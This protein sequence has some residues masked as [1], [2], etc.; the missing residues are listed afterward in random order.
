[1]IDAAYSRDDRGERHFR[2]E[3][4]PLDIGGD[5]AAIR[6]DGV[7]GITVARIGIHEGRAFV[8]PGDS[9]L[10][11]NGKAVSGSRWLS[12]GDTLTF[13]AGR[14]VVH[15]RGERLELHAR[16]NSAPELP[17]AKGD[18]ES[19][20]TVQP[21][22][23]HP[24]RGAGV[25]ARSGSRPVVAALVAVFA[26]LAAAAWFLFTANSVNVI[27]EPQPAEMA[28]EGT[29]FKPRV[30]GRYL[31]RPGEYRVVAELEGYRPL[32]ET[33]EVGLS[34]NQ[35]FALQME[36]LPGLLSVSSGE[37]SGAEV[38]IDGELIGTTP[39][40]DAEVSAGL[41]RLLVRARN[42]LQ[43]EQEIEI[44]GLLESQ[45][46]NITLQPNWAPVDLASEPAGATVAVDGVAVGTT[47]IT[48]EIEAGDREVSLSLAG[49]DTES[50]LI[51]VVAGEAQVLE[52]FVLPV[53]DGRL[54]VATTPG[55]VNVSVNGKFR[56]RTPL[57]LELEPNQEHRLA[58]AKPGY[59][60]ASRRVTVAPE[61]TQSLNVRL[62]PI[63]GSVRVVASPADAEL[64]VDGVRRG[65][66][67]QVLEL[68]AAPHRI[69]LRKNGY[70]THTETVTPRRGLE[71]SLTVVLKTV[72][73]AAAAEL[74]AKIDTPAGKLRLIQGGSLRMGSVRRE[75]G[76]RS[77]EVRRDV[78]LT[79]E[80]YI[81][82][83]EVTN[84]A[85]REFMGEHSSGFVGGISLDGDDQPVV[86]VSWQLAARFC[87]WMSDRDGLPKAYIDRDGRLVAVRPMNTGY[88]LPSEA[89][90]AWVAR[91]AGG[92][93]P[94]RY[95]WGDSLP[96]PAGAG[97]FA[98]NASAS[99]VAQHLDNYDDGFPV[100]APVGSF[101]ANRLGLKDLGGNVSEW[102]HDYYELNPIDPFL[103][104]VDP[105]GPEFGD[106]H[107][108]RG[109]SWMKGNISELRSAFRDSGAQGRPDLGFRVAR[110][111]R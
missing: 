101:A 19:W 76:R 96:P 36:K 84:A 88:R 75:Q 53:A 78:E 7:D 29:L 89:E 12:A 85:F 15:R 27:I 77:N 105:L 99:I 87:N 82:E 6:L 25:A 22:A 35:Q 70:A 37:L 69:E 51:N 91:F 45:S 103:S 46:L 13:D 56:G 111:A 106:R 102:T 47:P 61:E 44:A 17:P 86:R 52:P 10:H 109:A 49:Y 21:V 11:V 81:G 98:D 100:T 64:Y 26:V 4:F 94:L 71:Q 30:G 54:S 62:Q 1:M 97:N 33:I 32:D 20:E 92:P 79:R 34:A 55:A 39:L 83:T 95:P 58:L 63:I 57:E 38:L 31:L 90:W 67:G 48:A 80:F 24:E 18:D 73:E 50:R 41:H 74:P 14:L 72:A 110:Y 59:E 65:T 2:V 8:T 68:T 104:L 66:A 108:I 42:H 43:H 28:I 5:T 16:S 9:G 107:V 23:F 60:T 3:D 40:S 93:Q